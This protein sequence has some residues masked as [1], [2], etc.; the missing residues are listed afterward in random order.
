MLFMVEGDIVPTGYQYRRSIAATKADGLLGVTIKG[1]GRVDQVPPPDMAFYSPK[2]ALL[3][4]VYSIEYIQT[5][6]EAQ[7]T[8]EVLPAEQAERGHSLRRLAVGP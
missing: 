6:S 2:P 7:S 1:I 3:S 8:E 4:S 5:F